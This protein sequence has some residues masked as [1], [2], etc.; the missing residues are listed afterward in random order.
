MS[1]PLQ[2]GNAIKSDR[3]VLE[4]ETNKATISVTPP[5]GRRIAEWP[6]EPAEISRWWSESASGNHRIAPTAT[7]ASR[8]GAG[9]TTRHRNSIAPAG[10]GSFYP[11]NRWFPL[12]DSLH[13]RLISIHP[14][15]EPNS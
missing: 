8:R 11:G 6:G 5:C 13:H 9:T 2:L 15:G 14:P 4:V 7:D 12:A 3:G 10:A 1:L